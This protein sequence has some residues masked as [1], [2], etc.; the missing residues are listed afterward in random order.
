VSGIGEKGGLV[1]LDHM[2][3]PGQRKRSGDQQQRNHPVEPDQDERRESDGN[4]NHVQRTI[5]RMVMCAV[6]MGIQAQGVLKGS[7]NV[8]RIIPRALV[9]AL[10]HPEQ[11]S[12]CEE[13]YGKTPD[14]VM[15]ADCWLL[16]AAPELPSN[17]RSFAD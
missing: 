4:R 11:P 5:H 12:G 16:K 6:V 10:C 9:L 14:R 2:T 3:Q 8:A 1:A 7:E 17:V 15:L 13:S